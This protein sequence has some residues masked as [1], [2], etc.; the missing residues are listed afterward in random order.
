MKRI[1][2]LLAAAALGGCAPKAGGR[3]ERI[4]IPV[5][6]KGFQ[7]Q[8]WQAVRLGAEQAATELGVDITFEA[9]ESEA[10]L[11]KQA[12]MVAQALV[13]NPQALV[14]APLDTRALLPLLGEVR[15]LGIPLV[16]FDSGVE[17][18]LPVATVATDNRR[19]AGAAADRMAEALEGRGQVAVISHDQVSTTGIDRREGF[20]ERIEG[21]Y[22]DITIV[23]IQYADGDPL[24][25]A[26]AVKAIITANPELKG[27]FGTNEGSAVGVVKGVQELGK[28]GSLVVIGFDS[29]KAQQEAIR[30]GVQY[31]AISQNP[32]AIGYEAVKTAYRAQRGE[33]VDRLVDTGYVWYDASNIDDPDIQAVLYE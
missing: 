19:A 16:A 13:K 28:E 31:G 7:H 30:R 12:D 3:G 6:A 1:F 11:D 21:Q 20:V 10:M 17:G 24:K 25:S 27:V 33:A 2:L 18:D 32:L 8:F 29:G 23:S 22:P 4:Y 15:N 26:D 5:I 9:P 14:V